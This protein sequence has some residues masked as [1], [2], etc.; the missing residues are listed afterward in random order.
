[1]EQRRNPACTKLYRGNKLPSFFILLTPT[2]SSP[3]HT[4]SKVVC[5]KYTPPTA[6]DKMVYTPPP[7][8]GMIYPYSA[9]LH[10]RGA[11]SISPM[12]PSLQELRWYSSFQPFYWGG[13]F[14]E[15]SVY[16]IKLDT[17]FNTDWRGRGQ[18]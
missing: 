5:S 11:D 10:F 15:S 8:A 4:G 13:E 2:P 17:H 18:V 12:P 6:R 14:V 16:G 1:M 9:P 3:P 7:A